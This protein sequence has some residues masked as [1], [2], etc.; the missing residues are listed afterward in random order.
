MLRDNTNDFMTE[1]QKNHYTEVGLD[2]YNNFDYI[3]K[4]NSSMDDLKKM[5]EKLIIIK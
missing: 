3:I 4:N 5:A 2:N 1:E